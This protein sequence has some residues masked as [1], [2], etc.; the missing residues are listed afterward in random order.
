MLAIISGVFAQG[1]RNPMSEAQKNAMKKLSFLRSIPFL[2][3]TA[4]ASRGALIPAPPKSA[5]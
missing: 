3:P 1:A 2:K 4:P 5:I